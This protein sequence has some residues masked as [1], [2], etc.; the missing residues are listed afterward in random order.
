MPVGDV[1]GFLRAPDR[2]AILILLI[3]SAIVLAFFLFPGLRRRFWEARLV[4]LGM[5]PPQFEDAIR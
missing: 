5:D 3:R 2:I 1:A 4:V